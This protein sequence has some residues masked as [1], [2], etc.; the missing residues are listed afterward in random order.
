M[1]NYCGENKPYTPYMA[2]EVVLGDCFNKS[3][4]GRSNTQSKTKQM[5]VSP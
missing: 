2:A 3:T 1:H 5:I 4:E